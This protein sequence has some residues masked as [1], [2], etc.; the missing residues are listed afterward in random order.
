MDASLRRATRDDVD[1]LVR[2]RA[3]MLGA[4]GWSPEVENGSWVESA[5]HWFARRLEQPERFAAYVVDEPGRGVVS[6]A[7]GEVTES[8]PGPHNPAGQRGHVFNVATDA[9]RRRCGHAR[10]CMQSLLVWFQEETVVRRVELHASRDGIELYR[11]LGFSA[12]HEP[13]LQ[14]RLSR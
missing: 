4:L 14:L 12:P 1:D 10:R 3:V 13:A 2:L 5:T 7:V 6:V 9:D 8:A 11:S